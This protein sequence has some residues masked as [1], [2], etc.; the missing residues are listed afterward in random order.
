MLPQITFVIGPKGSGKTSLGQAL[1]KR[2][3]MAS[4]RFGNFVRFRGLDHSDDE[5]KVLALINQLA[6]EIKPRVLI[7]D[8]P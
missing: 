3:N 7:E 6:M 8:F 2:T 4:I 1:C 5:T